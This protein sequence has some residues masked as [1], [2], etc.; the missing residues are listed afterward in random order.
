MGRFRVVVTDKVVPDVT[1]ER[2]V[3]AGVGAELTLAHGGREDVLEVARDADALLNTYLPLDA[4]VIGRLTRCRIIARYGVGVDNVDLDAARKAGIVV[5]NVPDYC[6]EEVATHTL[7]LILTLVRKLPQGDEMVRAGRWGAH[8]LGPVARFSE[9]TVGLVGYGRI[10]R[11]LAAMVRAMGAEVLVHDP[12][13]GSPEGGVRL[14][15]LDQLLATADVV[16]LHCPLTAATHGLLDAARLGAMKP[17][18]VLVNAARGPLVVQHDLFE[19]LRNG[20]LTAAALD[21]FEREPPD[22]ELLASV[23]NL[24]VT[25][26][27]AFYSETAVRESRHKAA[28]QVARVLTGQPPDY[29]VT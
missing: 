14:V 23:P 28:T 29:P 2:E 11:R 24:L 21:V 8:S 17:G 20:V 22:A 18:A 3:L 4:D 19:A 15:E 13:V 27:A 26:H 1:V 25:P 9:L 10:A 5:T 12:Y 7:A 16:S 6:V